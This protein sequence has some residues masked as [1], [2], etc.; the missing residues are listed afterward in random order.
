MLLQVEA[1]GLTG[2]TIALAGPV[3][4]ALAR[5]DW[6]ARAPRAALLLWQAVGLGGG[7]GVLTAGM[8][9]AAGS[10]DRRWLPGVL[11]VPSHWSR[12]GP[13][14]WLG[15]AVTGGVGAWL[16]AATGTSAVRVATTRRAHRRF[17]DAIADARR[18]HAADDHTDL[19]VRLVDHPTAM[20]YCLPGI[21]PQIVLSRGALDTLS[22]GELTAVLAHEQ[23]HARGRH[24]LVIQP[25]IAWSKTFP[26][27]P[28]AARSVTAV[29][30]L[31]EMLADDAALHHCPPSDLQQ[32]L[33]QVALAQAA[34]I[35]P[36]PA[37]P[38]SDQLGARIDRMSAT[39]RALPPATRALIYAA[40]IALVLTPPVVLL[41]S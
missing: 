36:D 5:A 3:S 34:G 25:F 32:A 31:V 29:R 24:D 18:V 20:A 21:R 10:L 13:A 4:A 26:F 38:P 39:G 7:L 19:K 30:L 28:T 14:G 33:R 37:D 23:A 12:L 17:L 40:A 2:M 11:A 22:P 35:E 16:A 9:L 27:L 6:P 8:T 41:L 15:V 1:A